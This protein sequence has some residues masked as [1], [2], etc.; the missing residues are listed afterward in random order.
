MQR[1]R[2]GYGQAGLVGDVVE[3]PPGN[4]RL[5]HDQL[6]ALDD[7]GDPSGDRL[8]LLGCLGRA[9]RDSVEEL[10]D[11]LLSVWSG[12]RLHERREVAC[13]FGERSGQSLPGRTRWVECIVDVRQHCL[14]RLE[15]SGC[16]ELGEQLLNARLVLHQEP[17]PTGTL[18][19]GRGAEV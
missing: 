10:G 2:L 9:F 4:T 6:P 14:E 3:R 7:S 13:Q 15:A 12:E 18:R 8:D 1:L 16:V 17:W 19:F 11:L 5:S